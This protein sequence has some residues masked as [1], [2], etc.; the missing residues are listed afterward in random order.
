MDSE[1]RERITR[2]FFLSS[3]TTV[4]SFWDCLSEASSQNSV[5]LTE[6]TGPEGEIFVEVPSLGYL[7][8]PSRKVTGEWGKAPH[9]KKHFPLTALRHSR[10]QTV[11]QLH[12]TSD[13][14]LIF[15]I[16]PCS[17]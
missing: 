4:S 11:S 2:I 3:K 12:I 9:F 7:P 6:Q 8:W 16:T 1:Q 15:D 10:E 14:F 5:R 17:L 13:F